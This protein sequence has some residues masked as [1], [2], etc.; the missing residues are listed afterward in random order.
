MKTV[1]TAKG[2]VYGNYWGGGKGAYRS[3][4]IIANTEDA[5]EEVANKMLKEGSLDGGMG[6]ESLIG[7][8][9]YVTETKT[10]NIDGEDFKHEEIYC[11]F[12][13]DLTEEEQIF[14]QTLPF[15]EGLCYN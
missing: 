15:L 13:G 14:W 4:E 3:K 12:V 2:F 5:I 8:L 7:A 11:L 6:Y 1:Y 10:I 9:L